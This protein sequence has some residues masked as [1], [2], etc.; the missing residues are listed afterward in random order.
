MKV[1]VTIRQTETRRLEGEGADYTA[2]RDA[3]RAQVPEGWEIL[4]YR[5]ER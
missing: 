4:A 3:A 1:I 5:V 2:A